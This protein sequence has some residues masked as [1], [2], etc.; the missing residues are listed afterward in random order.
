M[1][2]AKYSTRTRLAAAGLVLASLLAACGPT[3]T[4]QSLTEAG[5]K[6]FAANDHAS[7][8]IR[9]KS[10]LQLD[11]EATE[12]RFQLGR[13][14]LKTGDFS[15]AQAE[16]TK[17]LDQK[18][19]PEQVM[20]LLAQ[21]MQ[22]AGE[23]KKLTQLY[24]D[25]KLQEP[26]AQ[27]ALKAW[28]AAAWAA[29]GN[30]AR[31]DSAVAASLEAVPGF[32]P[33]L[34][35]NARVLSSQDKA[36][37]ALAL[38]DKIL[39][40]DESLYEAWQL[41][42]EI[43]SV[44][45]KD[46]EAAEAAFQKVLLIE[47]TH[48]P[49]HLSLIASRLG[50]GDLPGAKAQAEKLRAVLP[51]HPQTLFVDAQIALYDQN[52]PKARE[53]S[54]QLLRFAP[55]HV[56]VLQLSGAIETRMGSLV[57]AESHYTKALSVSPNLP[58]ARRDLS[59]IY[60]RLGQPAKALEILQPL[61][62]ADTPFAD[63]QAAAGEAYLR[64][65]KAEEAERYFSAAARIDPGN[66][67][68]QTAIALA[69][70][71]RGNPEGAFATLEGLARSS[72]ETFADQAIVSARLKRREYEAAL[73]AVDAIALKDP[74]GFTAHELRGRI[75]VLR[76]DY[77]AA[78]G[79]FEEAL[80]VDPRHY[81]TTASLAALDMAEK[82]PADAQKRLEGAAQADPRNHH[83]RMALAD[84]R[85][86]T[87]APLAEVK[88]VL[89][90]AIRNSPTEAAPRLQ[91]IGLTL[92][93]RQYK[94]A[95]SVAQEAA[96][97]MPNDLAVL[98]A[99][100]RAQMEAGE[101]EQ[102]V[103]TFRRI[104]GVSA[105]S[106]LPW[107]R[108]AD[109]Y[110]ASGKATA[111]ENALRKALELEP[112]LTEAQEALLSLLLEGNRPREAQQVA[113]SMQLQRPT[114]PGGYGFEAMMH[115]KLKAPDAAV[116]ALRKGLSASGRNPEVAR[117][118]YV[119]MLRLERGAEADQFAAAWIKEHPQDVAFDY[120]MAVTAINRGDL[121]Q[122]ES[123]LRRVVE[124]RP[125]H[126]LAL[127]NLA[128]VLAQRNKPG[129][130]A[131]AQRAV[132]QFPDKPALLDTL[133]IALAADKQF[134]KALRAQ[135]EAIELLPLDGSLRLNLAKIAL[136]AGDKGLARTELEALKA[137]GPSTPFYKPATALL[138]TI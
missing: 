116:A 128:W 61:L 81:G 76:K 119:L 115:L 46:S 121:D 66:Q 104:A 92:Q 25:L 73:K 19:P 45:K 89:V 68:F 28:V 2:A 56:G 39:A 98:D 133:A 138:A 4:P 65:G 84:L 132:D 7:A 41:K 72:K 82:K 99:M 59:Q 21:A 52:L 33:A 70:I 48:L 10:A 102:A 62:G 20:P 14:L 12:A 9:Y 32:G 114:D 97:A 42:G 86:R 106:A 22:L 117:A 83:A 58:L 3:S 93:K 67:R 74:G 135:K 110:K 35:L 1:H 31:S 113:Q 64:L 40:A 26:R 27:A 100:G 18:Y 108:L 123:R 87:G 124:R 30:L 5:N 37:E 79:A 36:T 11:S 112:G 78:R 129:A 96:A 69:Q 80:K 60:L 85:L 44:L 122:A 120:Q 50:K 127:N 55:G 53:L 29:Q 71:S 75:H 57:L 126:P 94:E 13:A 107:I 38:V 88:S 134:D 34:I 51:K 103:T 95:L 137:K 101:V 6:A 136:K 17:A 91:L 131:F 90:E 118:L 8:V 125:N 54:Q 63:V 24:G 105:R 15:G 23:S 130:I 109:I 16:L 77:A 49:A 43:L 47:P 111:S